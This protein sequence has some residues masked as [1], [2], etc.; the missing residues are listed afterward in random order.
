MACRKDADMSQR[1]KEILIYILAVV[2]IAGVV[3]YFQYHRFH[4][5]DLIGPALGTVFVVIASRRQKHG[6]ELRSR[7]QNDEGVLQKPGDAKSAGQESSNEATAKS[8]QV[9]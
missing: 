7:R 5:W 6:D 3:V 9:T 8:N 4:W 1:S 2:V